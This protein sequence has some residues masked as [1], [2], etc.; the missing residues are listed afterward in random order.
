ME[1]MQIVQDVLVTIAAIVTSIG[2]IY[3]FFIKPLRK[4]VAQINENEK[5]N[6]EATKAIAE[7]KQRTDEFK[8]RSDQNDAIILESLVA[9]LDGLEQKGANGEVTKTKRKLISYMSRNIK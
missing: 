8:E 1:G 3:G 4:L 5:R 9:V 6:E 7:A 2:V